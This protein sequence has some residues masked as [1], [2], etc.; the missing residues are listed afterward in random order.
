MDEELVQ[1][2]TAL[3]SEHGPIRNA[4]EAALD[5]GQL[6]VGFPARLASFATTS[7]GGVPLR[8]LALTIVKRLI[9]NHHDQMSM[10]D[11]EA[12]RRVLLGTIADEQ[13]ALRS[14]VHACIAVMRQRGGAWPELHQQLLRGLQ[15]GTSQEAGFCVDCVAVLMEE[16]GSDVAISLVPLQQDMLR[17]AAVDASPPELRRKC[18]YA[19]LAGIQVILFDDDMGDS[20]KRSI[21]QGLPPW[22]NV[23]A[24][25]C[26]GVEG[27]TDRE[28]VACAFT[29]V[30]TVTTLCRHK[31]L[32]M[33][34]V[35]SIE[36]VL[37]PA[38]SLLQRIEPAYSQAVVHSDDG[39]ASE[40][41]DGI[42][43]ITAQVLELLQAM[44]TRGKL[45]PLL[46][47]HV[48]S[49]LQLLIPFM[50]ITEAQENAWHADPNEFL[51]HEEDEHVRGC[52]VRLSGEGLICELQSHMKRETG[53]AVVAI[54]SDL[55]E[56]GQ[57]G[58]AAGQPKLWKLTEVALFLFSV[59]AAEVPAKALQ[60]G[61]MA[62]LVLP[63]LSTAGRLC[64]DKAAPV[65]L[66][67][68]AFAVLRR[69]GDAV[70][71]L[72]PSDVPA[73]LRAA[74]MGLVP[75]EPIVI[76][77]SALR[78]LCRFL[79]A[80]ED[81]N[82]RQTLL[83][84]HGV[85]A[86]LGALCKEADEELLH[87][88][89]ES[90]CVITRLCPQ[91]TASVDT[92][93]V[94][95]VLEVWR[96]CAQDAMMH[97]Q[98]LDLVSCATGSDPKLQASMEANFLPAVSADLDRGADPHAT[99]SAIELL[100]VLLKRAEVPFTTQVWSLFLPLLEAVIRS[101]ESGLLQ[102]ACGTLLIF[103][104]RS[105]EQLI[106]GG[107]L[108]PTLR[109]IEH[110]LGPNLDDDA[111][112]YVPPLVMQMLAQFASK[113]TSDI[114]LGLLRALVNRLARA[115]MD[116]LKQELL[117]VFARLL[118]EDL[119]G[120]LSALTGVQVALGGDGGTGTVTSGLELLMSTWLAHARDEKIRAR[121]ARNVTV[122]ALCKLH[123]RCLEDSNLAALR[124]NLDKSAISATSA[125]LPVA[126]T[127]QLIS[128]IVSA[129]D[130]ENNRC[131]KLRENQL[132]NMGDSDGDDD[133]ND[134]SDDGGKRSGGR[135]LSEIV[136]LEDFDSDDAVSGD[137]QGDTFQELEQA[138]PILSLDLRG[139]VAEYLSA[140]YGLVAGS[141]RSELAARLAAA[142]ADV[143]A[144]PS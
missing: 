123:A 116:Y 22:L 67:A 135:L 102:N 84:D 23:H 101:D 2:L 110:L 76:R 99:S 16:C 8:Q 86:S 129:L 17:L 58:C 32:E 44:L 71:E 54:A 142:V 105:P 3:S 74:A 126:F 81:V 69:M 109:C 30:R 91:A 28:R 113:F 93:F 55:L 18:A 56:R 60:R 70:V 104:K 117:V 144:N 143:R 94:P 65:F 88:T 121:R 107:L 95:L 128:A 139:V 136:D 75:A 49:M 100:G 25:L 53:R 42:A 119:P 9:N 37:R 13:K 61:D 11:R 98:V 114:N 33:V 68:R 79:S 96:R 15:Q 4:A 97:C 10:Q 103:V 138:D 5:V 34:L 21:A 46:K 131:Q 20:G 31:P 43:Q 106:E 112:L 125:P 115:E 50:Q 40:D 6:Q 52:M 26:V 130:F 57:Q 35:N 39:G 133:D 137:G 85:F 66:R 27:W 124:V 132:T 7:A 80:T 134:E 48:K 14:L 73:L 90:L 64:A 19:H 118:H 92:S 78:V 72:L 108:A 82:C 45:R 12:L 89:L 87:L 47:G 127:E 59:A 77:A 83:M 63:A 29:A 141:G 122:S 36:N 140:Q 120:A 1:L 38:C 41:D 62:P 51:A 24:Q 111:C